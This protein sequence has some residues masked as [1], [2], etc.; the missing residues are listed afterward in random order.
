MKKARKGGGTDGNGHLG[1]RKGKATKGMDRR[2]EEEAKIWMDECEEKN[3]K[4][5][6][7]KARRRIDEEVREGGRCISMAVSIK[8]LHF[9]LPSTLLPSP[10]DFPVGPEGGIMFGE[11]APRLR[12]AAPVQ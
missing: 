4:R 9:F 8:H 5:K 10:V 11:I 2:Q 1:T 12:G 6:D 7:S 3:G